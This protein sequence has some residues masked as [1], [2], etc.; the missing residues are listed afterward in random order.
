MVPLWLAALLLAGGCATTSRRVYDAS[1]PDLRT[2]IY[3]AT[4]AWLLDS[5][6]QGYFFNI[7]RLMET[8][9]WDRRRAIEVQARARGLLAADEKVSIAEAFEKAKAGPAAFGHAR[10]GGLVVAIELEGVLLSQ[11][12]SPSGWS[13]IAGVTADIHVKPDGDLERSGSEIAV[14]PGAERFLGALRKRAGGLV[15][16][17]RKTEASARSALAAWKL[18]DGRPAAELFSEVY[19]RD[20]L[21]LSGTDP[22]AFRPSK[23]LRAIGDPE[24]VFL[25]DTDTGDVLQPERV[26]RVTRGD[27]KGLRAQL[28]FR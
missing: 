24:Q 1:E 18:A 16:F 25:V 20:H 17:T 14:N 22:R 12:S 27:L 21:V 19:T 2:M 7:E 28:P 15:V 26:V 6:S 4:P 3:P 9:G 23:D 13:R 10:P 11:W 5:T 8:Y